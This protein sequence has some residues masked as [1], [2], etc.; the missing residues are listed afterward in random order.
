MELGQTQVGRFNNSTSDIN[1]RIAI[2][3][4]RRKKILRESNLKVKFITYNRLDYN[5]SKYFVWN[6]KPENILS[7]DIYPAEK[8]YLSR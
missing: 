3:R 6:F 2:R 4:Q 8:M 7:G 1:S 5:K